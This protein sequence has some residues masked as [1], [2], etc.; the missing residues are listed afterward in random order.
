[1]G[2]F[3]SFVGSITATVNALR[4]IQATKIKQQRL[5]VT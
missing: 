3:S 1:M 4:S 5:A 2:C